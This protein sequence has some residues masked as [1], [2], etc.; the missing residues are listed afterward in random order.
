MEWLYGDIQGSTFFNVYYRDLRYLF[1]ARR[2]RS[3]AGNQNTLFIYLGLYV[4]FN[5]IG[6]ITT[7][8]F[9]GTGNH[10]IQLVKVLYHKLP[11]IGKKLPTFPHKVRG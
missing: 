7:G 2:T 4:V 10:Y 9:M 11:T 6:H 8:S 3:S 5:T 1:I